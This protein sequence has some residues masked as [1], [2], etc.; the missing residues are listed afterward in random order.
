MKLSE[1]GI[2]NYRFLPFNEKNHPHWFIASTLAQS[3][4]IAWAWGNT[5]ISVIQLPPRHGNLRISAPVQKG[6]G[7]ATPHRTGRW[8]GVFRT[9]SCITD[10]K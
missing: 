6:I 7:G 4:F 3:S 2:S 10:L 5:G 1:D 8:S 9:N